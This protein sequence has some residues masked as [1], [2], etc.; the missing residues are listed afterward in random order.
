MLPTDRVHA[1]DERLLLTHYYR[2][3]RAAAYAFEEFARPEVAAA[4]RAR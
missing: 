2:G 4:L 3:V 1:P